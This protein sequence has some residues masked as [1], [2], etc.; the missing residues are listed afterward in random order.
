[1]W[2]VAREAY[3]YLAGHPFLTDTVLH[4]RK[5]DNEQARYSR[6]N[7]SKYKSAHKKIKKARIV[8]VCVPI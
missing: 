4:K 7:Q 5:T 3:A 6:R 1:M 2:R 8:V